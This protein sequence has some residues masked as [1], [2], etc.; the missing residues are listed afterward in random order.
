MLVNKPVIAYFR[1]EM[2]AVGKS[3]TD[4]QAW[5]AYL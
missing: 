2:G 1:F 4:Q 3:N 5:A